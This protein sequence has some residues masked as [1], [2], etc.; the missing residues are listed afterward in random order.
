MSKPDYRKEYGKYLTLKQGSGDEMQARCPFHNDNVASLSVNMKTGLWNCF[1]ECKEGGNLSKFIE[2][3]DPAEHAKEFSTDGVKTISVKEVE[4]RYTRLM[5]S[6]GPFK[7]LTRERGL[8]PETIQKYLIGY[9]GKRITI[10]IANA[11]GNYVNIRRYRRG[12]ES[13]QSPKVVSFKA[14]YGK[15]QLFPAVTSKSETVFIMEGEMDC[16]LAR[17]MGLAAYTQ[18][19]GAT[20][21]K[22][23]FNWFFKDKSV[24]IVYDND[25]AGR[26]GA[27]L[28]ATS[29]MPTTKAIRIVDLPV[30]I[31]KEDFTDYIVK[32]GHTK[33]DFIKLCKKTKFHSQTGQQKLPDASKEKAAEINLFLASDSKYFEKL[34][35][36]HVLVIGKDMS[37]YIV[38]K[39]VS[40]TCGGGAK[41]CSTCPI[42]VSGGKLEI[43]IASDSSDILNFIDVGSDR[44]L[45]IFLK[46][47]SIYKC[48]AP[49]LEIV[50][51][52]NVEALTVIN[53]V[54]FVIDAKTD[55]TVTD[56]Y[57]TGHGINANTTYG[58]TGR[59]Y[60]H[61]K[62]QK[63]TML[64]HE[65]K[66]AKS[67][68]EAF[69][70]S[71]GMKK[72]LS[73]FKKEAK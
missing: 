73:I 59:I 35:K 53:D 49:S 23:E 33:N 29:L 26:K 56:V 37:P 5:I 21:W 11:K 16:L 54:E 71:N 28:V 4:D 48:T 22:P 36:L 13:A 9:D 47:L 45:K 51:A 27:M 20:T 66:P 50:E 68:I 55:Y 42:G 7:F 62:N 1:G 17:S 32:Y 61:P 52:G 18:T 14:G 15:C 40:L 19:A 69:N 44:H 10:P 65:A 41:R 57:F 63:A 6:P 8:T 39:K 31:T 43:K 64:V 2:K 12:K 60:P 34:V 38:P 58:L 70:M 46:R 72:E 67:S 24:C 25:D 3:I 30:K